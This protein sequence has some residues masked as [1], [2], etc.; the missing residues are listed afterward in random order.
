MRLVFWPL[1]P[2]GA[3][4][5]NGVEG[6]RNSRKQLGWTSRDSASAQAPMTLVST[7]STHDNAARDA[8]RIPTVMR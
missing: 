7:V 2:A 3:H 8:V 4:T 5:A 1:L 6:L